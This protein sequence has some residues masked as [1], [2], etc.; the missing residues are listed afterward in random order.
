M[1]TLS[2]FITPLGAALAYSIV[3]GEFL[4]AL[5]KAA[6]VKGVLAQRQTS[7]MAITLA[8][9]YPLCSL[10]SLSELA[11]VSIIGVISVLLTAVFMIGRVLD[12]TYAAGGAFFA[13]LNESLRPSFGA[14]GVNFLSGIMLLVFLNVILSF[15]CSF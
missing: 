11:P 15:H 13:T 14:K 3:L 12:G 2:C 6:G 5:A 9:L 1:V 8:V 4:S 10:K 7:I